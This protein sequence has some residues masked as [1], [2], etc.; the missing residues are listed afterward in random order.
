MR[1]SS[2][3]H[4]E[5]HSLVDSIY[6]DRLEKG[7]LESQRSILMK[8]LR[9]KPADRQQMVK[10]KS[11]KISEALQDVKRNELLKGI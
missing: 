10:S 6:E 3:K 4:P 8:S 11:K 5:Y 1:Y 9:S 7:V 2:K